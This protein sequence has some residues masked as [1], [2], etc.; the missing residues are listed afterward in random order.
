MFT[1][2]SADVVYDN[3]FESYVKMSSLE[4]WSSRGVLSCCSYSERSQ[5]RRE[6]ERESGEFEVECVGA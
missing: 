2:V 6:R 4:R 5:T 3:N 1:A